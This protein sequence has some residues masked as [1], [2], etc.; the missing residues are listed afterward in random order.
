MKVALRHTEEDACGGYYWHII[1]TLC[2][3]LF[4]HLR[5]QKVSEKERL[6]S[7]WTVTNENHAVS[8]SDFLITTVIFTGRYFE[9]KKDC[10]VTGTQ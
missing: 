2:S 7:I 1:I 5:E 10:H 4:F 9:L 8:I 6:E 3:A